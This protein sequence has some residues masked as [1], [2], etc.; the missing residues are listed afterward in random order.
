MQTTGAR[1]FV[2]VA[3]LAAVSTVCQAEASMSFEDALARAFS[4]PARAASRW[5]ALSPDQVA[6]ITDVCGLRDVPNVQQYHIV[7]RHDKV[8]GY[9]IVRTVSG[10]HGPIQLLVAIS[11]DLAVIRTEIL[12]LHERR[13]RPVRKQSFLAQFE[14]KTPA[15]AY[16]LCKEVDGITG[17][18]ISSRAVVQGV[19]EALTV[20]S[21][22]KESVP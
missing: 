2:L 5:A 14:G 11:P 18:T 8:V 10:K 1:S 19:R 20:L 7:T 16:A 17:A 21:V 6:R 15:H 3:V 9:A 12:S 13:G 22:I 4:K